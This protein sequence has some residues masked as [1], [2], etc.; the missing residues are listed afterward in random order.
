MDIQC[1]LFG[2]LP[3]DPVRSNA[4]AILN[5]KAKETGLLLMNNYLGEW[6][7]DSRIQLTKLTDKVNLIE[8]EI[9]GQNGVGLR[10]LLRRIGQQSIPSRVA[11][12]SAEA[13]ANQCLAA[14]R[15]L[16]KGIEGLAL[17]V[18]KENEMLREKVK[19]LTREMAEMRA[20][21]LRGLE[22][23]ESL[24]EGLMQVIWPQGYDGEIVWGGIDESL[25][26]KLR[27]AVAMHGGVA[28]SGEV[29]DVPSAIN[30]AG[31]GGGGGSCDLM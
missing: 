27:E 2:Y 31:R 5:A 6:M 30:E 12:V 9:L 14:V 11:A 18:L 17:G 4:V 22:R 15:S 25:A 20:G 24:D 28:Q 29:V 7:S 3:N 23:G 21:V 13:T 26:K 10:E 16:E 8:A 19:A 1:A